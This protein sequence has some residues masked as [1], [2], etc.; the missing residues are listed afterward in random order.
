MFAQNRLNP[1]PADPTQ[2]QMMNFMPVIFTFMFLN[3]PAGLVLYWLTNSLMNAVFQ[4]SLRD[5]FNS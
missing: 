1:A 4:L 2:A 3:F 5:H